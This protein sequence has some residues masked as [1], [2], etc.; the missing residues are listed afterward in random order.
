MIARRIAVPLLGALLAGC[1]VGPDYRRPEIDLPGR[2][3]GVANGE[4]DGKAAGKTDAASLASQNWREVF[5]DAALQKLIDEALTPD[6]S[7]FWPAGSYQIGSNPPSYD[8]QYVR[9]YL[10]T[11]DWN[12]KAPGPSLPGEVVART[13]AK[14]VEAYEQLTGQKLVD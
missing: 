1:A 14:Y 5:T 10:E 12:K 8:K 7:R 3:A 11:L 13:S 2:F 9:D 6:S 4:M